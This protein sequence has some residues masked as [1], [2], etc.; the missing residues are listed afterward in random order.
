MKTSPVFI[1][2]NQRSGT[3]LLRGALSS[4]H[5]FENCYEIFHP[6]FIDNNKKILKT[7]FLQAINYPKR[8]PERNFWN[9]KKMALLSQP[10]MVVPTSENLRKLF[11]LYI[12][13]LN[14]YDTKIPLVDVKYNSVHHL[15][16]IWR[17]SS[18][19]RPFLFDLL[20]EANIP[21][22]HL[23]RRNSFESYVSYKLAMKSG[24]WVSVKKS[25]C[26]TTKLKI[27]LED[28]LTNIRHRQGEISLYQKWL[29]EVSHLK[30]LEL[31]YE[32]LIDDNQE[33]SHITKNKIFDFLDI[34]D[35][36]ELRVPTKKIVATPMPALIINYDEVETTLKK[37]GFGQFLQPQE[38]DTLTI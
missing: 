29:K 34:K 31:D 16:P 12:K 11:S 21:V 3:N 6:K 17:H 9:F 30:I 27:N 26:T 10:H 38:L 33:F 37:N 22:I 20:A 1:I 4:C 23:I 28:M 18:Y 32:S 15:D 24:T 7:K 8:K 36:Y 5:L 2:A 19:E 25:A 14:L 13:E 35:N